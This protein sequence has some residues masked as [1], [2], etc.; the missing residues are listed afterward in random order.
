MFVLFVT[1]LIVSAFFSVSETAVT[2][3]SKV[4][5]RS[6]L[7]KKAKGAQA[8]S[9][10]L[11]SPKQ[12]MTA[13]GI[14]KMFSFVLCAVLATYIG[15]ALWPLGMIIGI[16]VVVLVTFLL[17][18]VTEMFSR[19][20]VIRNPDKAAM[21]LA[22]PIWSYLFLA[23]PIV[24]GFNGISSKMGKWMGVSHLEIGHVLASE[25]FR[26]IVKWGKEEAIL[27]KQEQEMIHSIFKFSD[28]IV[29]EIM[30]PRTDTA[31]L[32]SHA[33][34]ADAVNLIME[35]GHSRIPIF[36]A[37]IDNII[38]MVYAKDLLGV[39]KGEGSP[40]IRKFMRN[41]MFVPETKNVEDL[42]HTM[43]KSRYHIAI[44]LDEYGGMSGLVTMEDLIEEII[45]EIQDEY[46]TDEQSNFVELGEG[47]YLVDAKMHIEDLGEKLGYE[48]P[49]EEDFDTVGGFVLSLLGKFPARGEKTRYKN[50]D[51]C[52][53]DIS[54]RRILKIELTVLPED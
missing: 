49:V 6:L 13:I 10:I 44:C 24:R 18:I 3:I 29:R 37:K 5:L 14:G 50:L 19:M 39:A 16:V 47:K 15:M 40:P 53:K 27:E 43:K 30:T 45:G 11:K 52:I 38:G 36:E 48:F 20:L 41:P 46:D 9:S 54:K 51:L 1:C 2:T 32:D 23:R 21:L 25:D 33:T 22:R 35:T 12:F 42:L 7:E 26:A 28:T 31:C 34:V 17:V 8:L 4:K